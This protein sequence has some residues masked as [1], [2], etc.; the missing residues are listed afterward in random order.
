[1][2]YTLL[3]HLLTFMLV[4]ENIIDHCSC[5]FTVQLMLTGTNLDFKNILVNAEIN[6]D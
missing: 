5:Q 1:M 4:N 6:F 3:Q 2:S